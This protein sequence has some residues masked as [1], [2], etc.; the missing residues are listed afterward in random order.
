MAGG[1]LLCLPETDSCKCQVSQLP[2]PLQPV[3]I[4]LENWGPGFNV[5]TRP[6]LFAQ[7]SERTHGKSRR[8]EGAAVRI[9]L[10]TTIN[11]GQQL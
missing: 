1:A 10:T 3:C 4:D 2:G 5:L 11:R 8:K 7:N 6:S 9:L